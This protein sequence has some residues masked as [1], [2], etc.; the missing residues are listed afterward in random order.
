MLADLLRDAASG[1]VRKHAR[2]PL[3]EHL[4]DFRAH[5][6]SR[7]NT[8][9][10]VRTTLTRLQTP[11]DGCGFK[12]LADLDADRVAGWLK[13][14]RD[15]GRLAI[16]TSNYYVAACRQFGTWLVRSRRL[17]AN[18]L[19]HLDKLNADTDVRRE[20][21]A[22]SAGELARLVDAADRSGETFRGLTGRDRAMLYRVAVYTGLRASE[23]ASLTEASFDFTA[24][25]P[26]VTVEAAYSKRRRKDVLPIHPDLTTRLRVWFTERRESGGANVVPIHGRAADAPLWPGTWPERAARMLRADL[27][28]ARA[29]WLEEAPEGSDERQQRE[30]SVFLCPVDDDGRVFDFHG[31]RHQFIST[32]VQSGVHPKVTKELARHSTIT[33]TMDRYAHVGLVDLTA[34]LDMLP[35]LPAPR[36]TRNRPLGRMGATALWLPERLPELAATIATD[37]DRMM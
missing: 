7:G 1:P 37:C 11:F 15:A 22:L 13:D 35:A 17:P 3:A 21:R 25:P 20:R 16:Q 36:P 10:H 31:T 33:L 27:Q 28:A 6:E 23:L 29:A 8:A 26:T 30:K 24:D 32:L 14:E 12:R 5:L 18:P 9:K 4:E 2:R 34:A 19:A